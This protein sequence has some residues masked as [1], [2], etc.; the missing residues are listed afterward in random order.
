MFLW[1]KLVTTP[2]LPVLPPSAPSGFAFQSNLNEIT[3]FWT[4][5]SSNEDGFRIERDGSVIATVPANAISYTDTSVSAGGSYC[6]QITAFN[7]GGIG[8]ISQTCIAIPP[9]P[10]PAIRSEQSFRSSGF[11]RSRSFLDRQLKQ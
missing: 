1:R 11:Q 4:D 5:N 2:A 3:L 6:Y 8:S 9:I 10:I 7:S